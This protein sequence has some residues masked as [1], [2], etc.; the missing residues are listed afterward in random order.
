MTLSTRRLLG[1]SL[2]LDHFLD[3]VGRFVVSSAA[4][5]LHLVVGSV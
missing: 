5:V 3:F 4:T 1:V 2:L